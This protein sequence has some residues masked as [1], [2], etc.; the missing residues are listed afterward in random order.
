MVAAE[1]WGERAE[2][3]SCTDAGISSGFDFYVYC[4][5]EAG[6]MVTIST[7]IPKPAT[8][9]DLDGVNRCRLGSSA[10][11]SQNQ[12]GM[13]NAGASRDVNAC[14]WT[15]GGGGCGWAGSFNGRCQGFN[16]CLPGIVRPQGWHVARGN[17]QVATD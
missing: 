3:S 2:M 12:D 4:K 6:K 13:R 9:A 5:G 14:H 8:A 17:V 10:T 11:A 1:R 16:A 7:Q 15:K